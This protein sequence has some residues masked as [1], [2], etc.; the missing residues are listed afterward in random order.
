MDLG[1]LKGRQWC[2]YAVPKFLPALRADIVLNLAQRHGLSQRQIAA[3]LGLSQ[4]AV[5]HYTTCRRGSSSVMRI[6]PDLSRC[7]EK[8]AGRISR[9][10]SGARLTAALCGVCTSF[11]QG[12]GIG[13][14]FCIYEGV[15]KPDFLSSLGDGIGFPRQ[16]CETFVVK[17]LLPHIRSGVA[18][19]LSGRLSQEKVA[20]ALGVSQ[21]AVSQYVASGRGE[22]QLVNDVPALR[23]DVENLTER[24]EEGLSPEDRKSSICRI[25]VDFR[26]GGLSQAGSG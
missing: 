17:R 5:S 13:P 25:C 20:S 2:E 9:G 14:C 18:R 26:R 8:L 10:L 3:K 16:P 24:L 7:A 19:S 12:Q 4:A 6:Y 23:E 11:R 15:S 1:N 21:P 22:G